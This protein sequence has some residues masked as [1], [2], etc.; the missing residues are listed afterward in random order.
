MVRAEALTI[1]EGAAT[2]LH[3]SLLRHAIQNRVRFGAFLEG[4]RGRLRACGGDEEGGAG[5]SGEGG[6][7][8]HG[9]EIHGVEGQVAWE[10]RG[11]VSLGLESDGRGAAVRPLRAPGG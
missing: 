10:G 1:M 8:A 2:E 11:G 7:D 4:H 3:A 6:C 9:A 5:D